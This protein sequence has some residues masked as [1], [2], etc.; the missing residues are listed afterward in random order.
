MRFAHAPYS[1]RVAFGLQAL[2]LAQRAL[3]RDL[4]PRVARELAPLEAAV[5]QLPRADRDLA[6]P[7][8]GAF[9]G[10][11]AEAPE[12]AGRALR[13]FLLDWGVGRG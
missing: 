1:P 10:R 6:E 5:G 7:A 12:D 13:D 2:A 3:A 9:R 8:L 4:P 11:V